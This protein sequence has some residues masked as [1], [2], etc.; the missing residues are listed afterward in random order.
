VEPLSPIIISR[1]HLQDLRTGGQKPG[2]C[3]NIS[4]KKRWFWEETGLFA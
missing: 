4:R 2:F 1:Q 3:V